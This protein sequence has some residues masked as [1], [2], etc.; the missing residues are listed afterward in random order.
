M[1]RHR[2]GYKIPLKPEQRAL[3]REL[4]EALQ[5][6]TTGTSRFQCECLHKLSWA[7]IVQQPEPEGTEQWTCPFLCYFAARGLREDGNFITADILG[8][9]LAKFKY[10]CNSCTIVQAER[11]KM[12][13]PGGMIG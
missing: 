6:N 2:S 10:F 13:H 8:G 5:S 1:E 4:V 7:L 9:I 12:D 3:A 11:T